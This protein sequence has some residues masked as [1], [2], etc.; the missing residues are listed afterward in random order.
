MDQNFP[1]GV[2]TFP[3]GDLPTAGARRKG[4]DACRENSI[5]QIHSIAGLIM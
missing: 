4:H 2:V 3:K 5:S 1:A